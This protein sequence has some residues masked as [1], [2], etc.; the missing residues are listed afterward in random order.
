MVKWIKIKWVA[1][2]IAFC[3]FSAFAVKDPTAPLGWAGPESN[4][5]GKPNQKKHVLP[6]VNSIICTAPKTCQA[7]LNNR[8]V[9]TGDAIGR[10]K[11]KVITADYVTVSK[12]GKH[13]KLSMFALKIKE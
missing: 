10:Y 6:T 2:L 5:T 13:W 8:F 7:I 11:V 4:V 9:S 3:S 1:T 12:S